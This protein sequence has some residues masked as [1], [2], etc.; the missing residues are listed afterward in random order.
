MVKRGKKYRALASSYD[1]KAF[2]GLDEA[3][4]IL[5]KS[6]FKFDQTV[7]LHFNLGVDPKHSDQMVRGSVTLP[8]GTGRKVRILALCKDNAVQ[9][10]TDAGAD[11]AGGAEM[12]QKISE[13]WLDFD[14]VVA[15]PD[16][17]AVLGKVAKVLGPRGLMPSPK[18]GTVTP[19]LAQ[20]IKELKAGKIQYRVDKGAN[21]HTPVGKLSFSGEQ[22]RENI[23]TVI[24]SVKKNK[25]QTSKGVYIKSLTLTA[26]MTPSVRLDIAITR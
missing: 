25:P 10:A 7:E 8:H 5:K 23:L 4:N 18:A 14:A 3:V 21:V 20:I 16:M 22:L 13:G 24:D 6:D 11:F 9:A 15:T 26:T 2:H 19:N 12:V 1:I 17:M